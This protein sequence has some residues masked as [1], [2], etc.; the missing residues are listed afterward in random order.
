MKRKYSCSKLYLE[1]LLICLNDDKYTYLKLEELNLELKLEEREIDMGRGEGEGK[2]DS[3]SVV[4][5]KKAIDKIYQ[6]VGQ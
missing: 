6:K 2:N 3:L 5:R 1:Y 4:R